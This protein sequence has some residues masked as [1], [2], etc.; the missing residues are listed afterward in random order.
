MLC[1]L[2]AL[3]WHKDNIMMIFESY[4]ATWL[5]V[6]YSSPPPSPL[7]G[8]T[9]TAAV[10]W[11]SCAGCLDILVYL[12]WQALSGR[13]L[14]NAVCSYSVLR[15]AMMTD[16]L[17]AQTVHEPLVPRY[18]WTSSEPNTMSSRRRRYKRSEWMKDGCSHR[19]CVFVG[20]CILCRFYTHFVHTMLKS[21]WTR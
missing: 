11:R 10:R 18:R 6:G 13:V 15:G 3:P 19:P 2:I 16:L 7:Y 4:P 14:W 21:K 5:D 20:V 8:S 12:K 9:A 1:I 17:L